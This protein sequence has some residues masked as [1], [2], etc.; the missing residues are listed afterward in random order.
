[1]LFRLTWLLGYIVETYVKLPD[2]L[3]VKVKSTKRKIELYALECEADELW[4]F[5][6]NKDNKHWVRL[7]IDRKTRQIF[8][9]EV[10]MSEFTK[11]R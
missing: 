8:F 6:D 2:Y 10:G 11:L 3:N 4:N 5:V 1:M 7:A 9:P